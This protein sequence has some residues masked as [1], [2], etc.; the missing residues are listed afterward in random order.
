MGRRVLGIVVLGILAFSGDVT[1]A[2]TTLCIQGG[3]GNPVITAPPQDIPVLAAIE[4]DAREVLLLERLRQVVEE[5]SL[6][7]VRLVERR[8]R[9]VGQSRPAQIH[10]GDLSV[11]LARSKR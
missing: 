7:T 6:R 1:S 9:Y 11:G 2:S 10:E 3:T 4:D 5:R 8:L